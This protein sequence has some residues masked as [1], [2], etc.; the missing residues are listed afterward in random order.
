MH[1]ARPILLLEITRQTLISQ[2]FRLP[3]CETAAQISQPISLGNVDISSQHEIDFDALEKEP[4]KCTSSKKALHFFED[5]GV[6]DDRNDGELR[7]SNSSSPAFLPSSPQFQTLLTREMGEKESEPNK[8]P[9]AKISLEP[10]TDK[11][12]IAPIVLDF[13][14]INDLTQFILRKT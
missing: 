3:E 1:L 4:G 9:S 14:D 13:G 7:E 12:Q 5:D 10:S 8:I 6:E 2:S 11:Q